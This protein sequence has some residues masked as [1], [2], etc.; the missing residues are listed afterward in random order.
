ML[1]KSSIIAGSENVSLSSLLHEIHQSA[2]IYSNEV[3]PLLLASSRLLS[4]SF[5]E[6]M[7]SNKEAMIPGED[8]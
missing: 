6:P 1:D 2:V 8:F 5:R 4:K 7:G 3:S